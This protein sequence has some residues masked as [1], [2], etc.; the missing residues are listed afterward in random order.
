MRNAWC[1]SGR[2]TRPERN[3]P[4]PALS[5]ARWAAQVQTALTSF[6]AGFHVFNTSIK[7]SCGMF[8]LPTDFMRFLPSFCFSSSLRLRVMSPP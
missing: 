7:A 5:R 3:D 8:T 1:V 2:R 4:S 6:V